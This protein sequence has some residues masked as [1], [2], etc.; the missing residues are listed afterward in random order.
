[1]NKLEDALLN[2]ETLFG[3]ILVLK[4]ANSIYRTI[5]GLPEE[6]KVGIFGY[7]RV[8]KELLSNLSTNPGRI[9]KVYIFYRSDNKSNLVEK[10][11]NIEADIKQ[12]TLGS[13]LEYDLNL[14]PRFKE[15]KENIDISIITA[16]GNIPSSERISSKREK[17]LEINLPII[18]DI[19]ELHHEFNG[20]TIIVTNPVD[21]LSYVFASFSG[22]NPK[23]ITG[24]TDIDRLRLNQEI[25]DFRKK[26]YGKKYNNSDFDFYVVGLHLNEH[27]TPLFSI[28]KIRGLDFDE[29]IGSDQLS[30]E[31]IKKKLMRHADEIIKNVGKEK[32]TAEETAR[33]IKSHI[34]SIIT[35]KKVINAS[36]FL[37]PKE[38]GLKGLE[39]KL[40]GVNISYPIKYNCNFA[41]A[42]SINLNELYENEK[43]SLIKSYNYAN[44]Q[45]FNIVKKYKIGKIK[46]PEIKKEQKIFST[47]QI[48]DMIS[49]TTSKAIEVLNK[50]NVNTEE[51]GRIENTLKSV[52]SKQFLE[53]GEGI[54]EYSGK[55]ECEINALQ[56]QIVSIRNRKKIEED[57]QSQKLNELVNPIV[58]ELRSIKGKLDYNEEV[59]RIG[60]DD[61]VNV[62][63]GDM[64]RL[65]SSGSDDGVDLTEGDME[66]LFKYK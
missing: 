20:H 32:G 7:G 33:A 8:G 22:L 24:L 36:I 55:L 39:A 66:R 38:I 15:L 11:R 1:M 61:C 12:R 28:G 53:L 5:N 58:D 43:E 6:Y 2:E 4:T 18:K 45:L 30:E 17:Q 35:Q 9:K 52:F 10:G 16:C 40:G 27:I 42:V 25:M 31:E 23:Q 29:L 60:R 51:L 48:E 3:N 41:E 47:E 46:Y 19:A 34:D 56:K 44:K 62:T 14:Y 57:K 13:N 37:T 50:K 59:I 63:E 64:E 21:F 65:F 26:I 54:K 49:K